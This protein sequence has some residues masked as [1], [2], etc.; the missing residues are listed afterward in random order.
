MEKIEPVDDNLAAFLRFNG[1]L[2]DSVLFFFREQFRKDAR[3][4][5]T[6]TA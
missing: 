4:Q 2:G 1:L 5:A 3:I 6:Q